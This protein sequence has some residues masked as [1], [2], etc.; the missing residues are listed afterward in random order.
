[1]E[2]TAAVKIGNY[3]LTWNAKIAGFRELYFPT[4]THL[5]EYYTKNAVHFESPVLMWVWSGKEYER[6]VIFHGTVITETKLRHLLNSLTGV[7]CY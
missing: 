2:T 5:Q 7:S 4:F 6:F 3:R 1:M